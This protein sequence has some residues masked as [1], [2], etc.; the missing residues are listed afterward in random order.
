VLTPE[1]LL[2]T[3]GIVLTLRDQHLSLAV[4]DR[5]HGHDHAEHQH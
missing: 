5:E 2:E 3:F 4:V 1:R